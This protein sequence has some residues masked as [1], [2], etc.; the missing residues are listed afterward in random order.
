MLILADNKTRFEA[1]WLKYTEVWAP[2]LL[3]LWLL[4]LFILITNIFLNANM[5]NKMEMRNAC[6]HMSCQLETHK[7]FLFNFFSFCFY[8]QHANPTTKKST[9]VEPKIEHTQAGQKERG[10]ILLIKREASPKM[11]G[12]RTRVLSAVAVAVSV[13]SK[14]SRRFP[15]RVQVIACYY[16]VG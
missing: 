7:I 11:G 8:A 14:V 4:L 10:N 12:E 6:T 13:R 5:A 16:N 9:R 1:E 3:P 2:L 15:V